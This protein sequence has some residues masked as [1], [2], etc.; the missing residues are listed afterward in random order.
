MNT[1]FILLFLMCLNFITVLFAYADYETGNVEVAVNYYMIDWI[2]DVE[3]LEVSD[4]STISNKGG[5]TIAGG[6][7]NA[8]AS[9][10]Q[11]QSAG[12]AQE[13]GFF[14]ILDTVKMILALFSLLTP[15]PAITY[16]STVGLPLFWS[17]FLG[18]IIGFLYVIGLMEFLK[19]SSL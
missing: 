14:N 17:M 9:L 11:Q 10:D 13:G 2:V 5:V 7:E 16:F 19:G 1:K 12:A 3:G 4:L 8:T 18:A 6:F 15:L